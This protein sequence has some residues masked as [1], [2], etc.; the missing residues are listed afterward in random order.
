MKKYLL[1]S[2]LIAVFSINSVALNTEQRLAMRHSFSIGYGEQLWD[3]FYT[4]SK[5]PSVGETSAIKDYY[6][7]RITGNIYAEYMYQATKVLSI[8]MNVNYNGWSS[9]VDVYSLAEGKDQKPNT[10]KRGIHTI[11]LI[12]TLNFTYY[13]NEKVNLYSGFGIGAMLITENNSVF[14]LPA[15]DFCLLGVSFGKGNW[16]GNAEIGGLV[17]TLILVNTL[18]TR[19]LSVGFGYRF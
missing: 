19:F 16:F 10:Y 7:K 18:P 13:N 9:M 15:F 14:A 12:P 17:S 2:L 8:G 3:L 11:G 4:G 1:L 5:V 6:N